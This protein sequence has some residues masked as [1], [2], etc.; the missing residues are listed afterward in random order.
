MSWCLEC[1]IVS[2]ISSVIGI[3]HH[4][5]IISRNGLHTGNKHNWN[6]TVSEIYHSIH[7][8]QYANDVIIMNIYIEGMA[9]RHAICNHQD[10]VP[11]YN[12]KIHVNNMS[13]WV[14]WVVWAIFDDFR[15]AF[16][17]L[18]VSCRER[19]HIMSFSIVSINKC[20][21]FFY[22]NITYIFLKTKFC[23][24]TIYKKYVN[25]GYG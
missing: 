6:V 7:Y 15:C 9:K 21:Q 18:L 10:T 16:N 3:L 24:F 19:L 1:L 23:T 8:I 11:W 12:E 20:N 5:V 4:L 13:I 2:Y 25:Q 17:K 14:Y 22:S